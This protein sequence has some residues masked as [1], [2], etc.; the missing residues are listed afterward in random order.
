M[1]KMNSDRARQPSFTGGVVCILVFFCCGFLNSQDLHPGSSALSGMAQLRDYQSERISSYDRTGIN[2]DRIGVGAG[3]T[4]IL[5]DIAGAG[6]IKH[7]WVTIASS[8]PMI[9]RNAILRMYWDGEIHPSV[10]SPI[11]DFFGNGWAENYNFISLPLATAPMEGRAMNCYFPMPFSDGARITLE[12]QSTD[13]IRCLYYIIDYEVHEKIANN[14]GRFHAWWNREL[15]EPLPVGENEYSIIEPRAPNTDDGLRN[16]L[17]ADI[18]GRGHFAGVNYYVDSP[19][20]IWYGE[21]DDMFFIDGEPWPPSLH[22]TGTEDFFNASWCPK[23]IYMHPYFG[24]ARVNNNI[25]HLGRTHCYRFFIE[26]PIAF[27]KSCRA[28][29]E[30]GHNNCLT[31]DISTVAYW[32]Q[33]EPHKP[34]PEILPKD[35]RQNFPPIGPRMIHKWRDAWRQAM[36]G[37]VLWGNE[38]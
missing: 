37:K 27:E 16:Y 34:F 8:D 5:A 31:L 23:E 29:I 28:T 24:Y 30:H 25:G 35:K 26:S 7:I 15:S 1:R 2:V 10:E 14:L 17:I 12:N 18:H 9:R 3:K 38:E 36:G 22:G 19:T 4:A 6:I 13:T 32:Y 20:P 11:G 21:G 33:V